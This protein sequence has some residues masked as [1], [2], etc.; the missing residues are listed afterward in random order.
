[1]ITSI[2]SLCSS[3]LG[4]TISIYTFKKLIIEEKEKNPQ[5]SQ[6]KEDSKK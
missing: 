6:P 4:L 3:I 5:S 2:V 1:M